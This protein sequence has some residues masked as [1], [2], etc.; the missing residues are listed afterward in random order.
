MTVNSV[1][2][3]VHVSP[4]LPH[5]FLRFDGLPSSRRWDELIVM[6]IKWSLNGLEKPISGTKIS[7]Q[8]EETYME[9]ENRIDKHVYTDGLFE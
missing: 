6:S 4:G 2:V 5:G 1:S 9:L 7:I 8:A 3:K